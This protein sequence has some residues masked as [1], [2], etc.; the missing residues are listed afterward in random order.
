MTDRII[1]V[2]CPDRP[3]V[4]AAISHLLQQAGGNIVKD[5]AHREELIRFD[6][7]ARRYTAGAARFFMRLE[8][9]FESAPEGL[10]AEAQAL[11]G[12]LEGQ[13]ACFDPA[14]PQRVA[15]L[16]SREESCLVDLLARRRSGRL[17]CEIPLVLSDHDA[18]GDT[19]GMYGVPFACAPVDP[20]DP[21]AHED[22]MRRLLDEAQVDLVVLARY[23]RVLSAAFVDRYAERIINVHHGLLPAFK[24]AWPYHQ[25][26]ERGVKVIGAT[27]HYATAELD[28]GPIIAQEVEAVTHRHS[29]EELVETGRD[30][31]RRVLAHA[32]KAWLEHRIALHEGRTVV[33]H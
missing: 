31:E 8:V 5:E 3:G 15:I 22:R 28:A 26:W 13:V 11:A 33:F 14:R 25:A 24:G 6:P 16:V 32:V 21:N 18:L 19:A 7:H 29:A 2:S 23:M 4:V 27:A 17:P 30:L 9:T 12:R 10:E 1:L 20:D